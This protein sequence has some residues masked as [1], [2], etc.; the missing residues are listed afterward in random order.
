MTGFVVF[1]RPG[2][3]RHV[4]F[5]VE[6]DHP[7]LGTEPVIPLTHQG[8]YTGNTLNGE[9]KVSHYRYPTEGDGSYP[10]PELVYQV[11]ITGEVAN[12]GVAV[13]QGTATPQ[14]VFAGDED[15]LVGFPAFPGDINPYLSEF[16]QL[17]P[18]AAAVLP[19]PG[20]YDIVFDTHSRAAAGAFR[21]RYW[22]NDTTPPA[23][24]VL[25][26][27]DDKIRLSVSDSGSG[28]DPATITVTL[29]GHGETTRYVNGVVTVPAGP[30]TH[31]V[32]MTVSDYEETK[33]MEDV[34][35]ILPNTTNFARTL[36]VG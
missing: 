33:N 31:R 32:T 16:G 11:H 17:Q 21:F 23:V 18:V 15:H 8:T 5:W 3:S 4:P 13:L 19:G 27:T 28:V 12:F 20:V 24:R 2:I 9:S 10:G 29:D 6:V 7:V 30:G 36:T 26:T 25:S 34:G 14:I 1:T 22:I 35:P